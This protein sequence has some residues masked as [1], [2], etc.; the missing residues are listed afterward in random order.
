MAHSLWPD[1][2][3]HSRLPCLSL[4]QSLLKFMSFE[5]VMLSNHFILCYPLFFLPSIFPSIK[6]YS[7][8]SALHIRWP[9]YCILS[10][11]MSLSNEYSVLI[12]LRIDW[13]DLLA[14]QR[15]FQA[16]QFKSINSSAIS[17]LYA[18]TLTVTN[19]YID[20]VSN[21]IYLLFNSCLGLS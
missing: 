15:H 6:V 16:P 1:D 5:S 12:S 8:E 17:L 7:N 14:I 11:S 20:L 13:F 18:Q 9:K 10:F 2:P 19:D 21:V 3:Q 4:S